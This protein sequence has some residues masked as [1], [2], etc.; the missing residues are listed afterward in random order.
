MYKKAPPPTGPLIDWLRDEAR[1]PFEAPRGDV[2]DQV[3]LQWLPE[4]ATNDSRVGFAVQN[5]LRESDPAVTDALLHVATNAAMRRAVAA[6]L[7]AAAPTL[8]SLQVVPQSTMLG[9]AVRSLQVLKDVGPLA[10]DALAVLHDID[11]PAD[12]WP[13]SVAIG[14]AAATDRFLDRVA[15]TLAQADAEQAHELAWVLLA[16][17]SESAIAKTLKH[18]AAHTSQPDREKFGAALKRDLDEQDK[19]H[20]QLSDLGVPVQSSEPGAQ[21]WPRYAGYLGLTP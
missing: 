13:S 16:N 2:G 12:G 14:L 17:A 21:R 18:A 11:R 9:R 8:A 10:D 3:P 20:K 5:L 7:G 15:P 19:T 4:M 1:A 6:V